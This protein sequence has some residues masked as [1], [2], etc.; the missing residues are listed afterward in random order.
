MINE[1]KCANTLSAKYMVKYL[2]QRTLLEQKN[3]IRCNVV[4][5]VLSG[6]Y[7]LIIWIDIIYRNN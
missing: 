3:N 6:Q 1:K 7:S 4:M 2:N 5:K